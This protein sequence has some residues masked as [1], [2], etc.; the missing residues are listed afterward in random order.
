MTNYKFFNR[1]NT[2]DIIISITAFPLID[3]YVAIHG[4]YSDSYWEALEIYINVSHHQAKL[5]IMHMF[6]DD[7]IDSNG[8]EYLKYVVWSHNDGNEIDAFEWQAFP[9]FKY[10]TPITVICVN[11]IYIDICHYGYIWKYRAC[12][13]DRAFG[14]SIYIA[15]GK[16]QVRARVIR[17]TFKMVLVAS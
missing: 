6:I 8:P 2:A 5:C 9:T 1:K 3:V 4:F 16:S 12:S 15:P 7:N 11:L 14:G 17:K 13:S 10:C